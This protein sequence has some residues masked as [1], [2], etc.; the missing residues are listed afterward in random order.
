VCVR[1]RIC[2][3]SCVAVDP[4]LSSPCNSILV[5]T[6][7]VALAW[8]VKSKFRVGWV[9]PADPTKGFK[10]LYLTP[11]D[12]ATLAANGSVIAGPPTSVPTA[13]PGVGAGFA[14]GAGVAPGSPVSPAS[15]P[16]DAHCIIS[17]IIGSGADLGVENLKGSAT[18]AGEVGVV[19]VHGCS[20]AAF[21][22]RAHGYG[23]SV[24]SVSCF[25]CKCVQIGDRL[26]VAV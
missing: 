1:E 3:R 21:V 16:A 26:V 4:S 11:A 10:Y 22:G 12:H 20:A 23:P 2:T 24:H 17:D 9:D 15:P 8:Q 13:S 7:T 18:I 25:P 5:C 19:G 6:V 14:L